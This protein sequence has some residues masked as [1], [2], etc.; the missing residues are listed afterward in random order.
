MKIFFTNSFNG[1]KKY[2]KYYD[3]V[4][5][6]IEKNNIDLISPEKNNYQ[7]LIDKKTKLKLKDVKAIHYEAIKRGILWADI[8]IIEMS[9][10]D[11]QLGYEIT[12]AI[13]NK[14]PVLCLSIYE[15][16]S[17][18]IKSKYFYGARYNQFNINEIIKKFIERNQKEFL[19]QRFNCFLAPAQ[20]QYL[21]LIS[22]KIGMNK[23]EYLRKL[24]D[25][26]RLEN[27]YN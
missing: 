26:D 17:E 9:N 3:I 18:K 19:T 27:R 2:Q 10:E 8:I 22:K 13:Q 21:E 7:L 24:I 5:T 20:I 25:D 12:L 16:F 14:K 23:S 6:S 4:R 1:K 15:D 11:F